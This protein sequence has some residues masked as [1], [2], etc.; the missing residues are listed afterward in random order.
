MKRSPGSGGQPGPPSGT[1]SPAEKGPEANL[2]SSA[3]G[4]KITP[5]LSAFT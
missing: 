3:F 2:R 5:L 1:R 4:A